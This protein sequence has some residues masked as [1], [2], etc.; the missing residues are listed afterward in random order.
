MPTDRVDPAPVGGRCEAERDSCNDAAERDPEAL[1]GRRGRGHEVRRRRH[2]AEHGKARHRDDGRA[3]PPQ[4]LLVQR[5][6]QQGDE[7]PGQRDDECGCRP[8]ADEEG[9][10]EDQRE[11]RGR[12]G[13]GDEI[14][15]RLVS[16][17]ER[18][19]DQEGGRGREPGDRVAHR[20]G[21]VDGPDPG[22]DDDGDECRPEPDDPAGEPEPLLPQGPGEQAEDGR[23]DREGNRAPRRVAHD[24]PLA[25]EERDCTE[26][27]HQRREIAMTGNAEH[28]RREAEEDNASARAAASRSRSTRA[29]RRPAR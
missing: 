28:A 11:D 2:Q 17:G 29:R 10:A 9:L 14:A 7:R 23:G 13:D 25:A 27:P 19:D 22:E 8:A 4:S 5:C 21:A 24:E 1:G 20:L 3:R 26:R 15:P 6:R 16:P 18:A 12:P